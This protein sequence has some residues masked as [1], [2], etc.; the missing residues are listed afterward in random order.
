[1]S[2]I[3]GIFRFDSIAV[4]PGLVQKMMATMPHRSPDG[5]GY[6]QGQSFAVGHG[7]FQT[8][9]ESLEETQPLANESGT[10]VLVMDGRVD[11]WIE[12]RHDLLQ[13]G[14]ILRTRADAELVLRAYEI[15]GAD[16]LSRID[17]DFALV[18]G[19]TRNG[20]AFCARDRI[21]HKPLHYHWDGKI[22]TFA[23]EPQAILAM[24]WVKKVPN[25]GMFAEFISTDWLSRDETFWV[26][27][28]RLV[29]AHCTRVDRNGPLPERYWEP[30]LWATLSYQRDEE[31]IEHY[32]ELLTD[33][34]RRMS[35]SHRPISSHVSGGLDSSA[36]FSVAHQLQ[37]QGKLLAPGLQGHT[38]AFPGHK[39]ADELVYSRAVARHLGVNIREEA[40]TRLLPHAWYQ[41][42]AKA[43]QSYP[44]SPN[45]TMLLGLMQSASALGARVMLTGI[46]GDEWLWTSHQAYYQEELAQGNWRRLHQ[47]YKADAQDYGSATAA[48]WLLRHGVF[49]Q[50]PDP[51][52]QALRSLKSVAGRLQAKKPDQSYW[53]TPHM[54]QLMQERQARLRPGNS[55]PAKN[56]GQQYLLPRLY[57][58]AFADQFR[59]HDD[60]MC[61]AVNIEERNPMFTANFVQ[62]ALS[63][64]DRMRRRGIENKYIHVK[65]MQGLLPQEVLSRR[66][67]ADFCVVTYDHVDQW[68]ATFTEELPQRRPDWVTPEGMALLRKVYETDPE[69]CPAAWFLWCLYISEIIATEV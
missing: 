47:A 61:A 57:E 48:Y 25:E 31:Y 41:N 11:N 62:F 42:W 1:M 3:A 55:R 63:T 18:V 59:E 66:D 56:A 29:A 21:G 33:N 16:C 40:P 34:V 22:F 8:T 45:T 19:D 5:V 24:P 15:W 67:K 44:G 54:K 9:P 51:I 27:V 13:R 20:T 52:R 46:G 17:G 60:R 6:W 4:E 50:L 28:L 12:L 10:L 23:S 64:P 35:R 32:L 65:A 37:N 69:P 38:L 30:D 49:Q 7:M 53:L 39:D 68:L 2:G 43:T 14:A 36:V 26:N 58:W